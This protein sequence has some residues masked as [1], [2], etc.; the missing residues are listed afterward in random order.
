MVYPKRHP[1]SVPRSSARSPSSAPDPEPLFPPLPEYDVALMRH[2]TLVRLAAGALALAG[3]LIAAPTA[4]T[5]RAGGAPGDVTGAGFSFTAFASTVRNAPRFQLGES[6]LSGRG[7]VA[8]DGKL[9]VRLHGALRPPSGRS[10]TF[11]ADVVAWRLNYVLPRKTLRLQVEVGASSDP[12]GCPVG[13][14]GTVTIVDD[15]T[16]TERGASSDSVRIRFSGS[17]CRAFARAWSN[18]DDPSAEPAFGGPGGGNRA[19]VEIGLQTA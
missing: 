9:R 13:T 2:S 16:P 11:A 17:A 4:P 18:L 3:L 14:R 15:D 7:S 6:T 5:A 10:R 12:A 19:S 1:G 8:L